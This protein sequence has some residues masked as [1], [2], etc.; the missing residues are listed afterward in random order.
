[1][2]DPR[3]VQEA[4]LRSRTS[5]F[6]RESRELI[7][8]KHHAEK[9]EG[10][11]TARCVEPETS[12]LCRAGCI[13]LL[14]RD[15]DAGGED[16]GCERICG[17]CGGGIYEFDDGGE[18][19][20]RVRVGGK[21]GEAVEGAGAVEEAGAVEATGVGVTPGHEDEDTSASAIGSIGGR[22]RSLRPSVALVQRSKSAL[23]PP[24]LLPAAPLAPPAPAPSQ[25]VSSSAASLPSPSKESQS[26][27]KAKSKS[28]AGNSR[29][30]LAHAPRTHSVADWRSGAPRT[31]AGRNLCVSSH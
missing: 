23:L 8:D 15:G 21:G 24:L 3:C 18:Q 30:A 26:R 13:T 4:H 6:R 17:G 31:G 14:L 29:C 16:E 7:A 11:T 2:K 1:M 12:T 22:W 27:W 28:D 10:D 20:V 19:G 5:S 25:S 9:V